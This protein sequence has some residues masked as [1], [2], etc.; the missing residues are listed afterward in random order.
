M[1]EETWTLLSMSTQSNSPFSF[2]WPLEKNYTNT[3]TKLDR[4]ES[5]LCSLQPV[6]TYTVLRVHLTHYSYFPWNIPPHSQHLS[7]HKGGT[8]G[9]PGTLPPTEQASGTLLFTNAASSKSNTQHLYRISLVTLSGLPFYKRRNHISKEWQLY[10]T[11][12][13]FHLYSNLL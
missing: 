1:R 9:F 13:S 11:S 8:E 10:M 7:L 12:D 3:L 2:H 6:L 4:F 5:G